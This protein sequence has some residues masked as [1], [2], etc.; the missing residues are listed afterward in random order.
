MKI[1]K[2]VA[3]L[4]TAFFVNIKLLTLKALASSSDLNLSEYSMDETS[5]GAM[6]ASSSNTIM[7]VIALL[8]LPIVILEG[9][10][11]YCKFSKSK[12]K[13]KIII[14]AIAIIAYIIFRICY[15]N[16]IGK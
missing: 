2:K 16:W 1:F 15:F 10:F 14:S 3:K 7:N 4:T 12:K 5:Y 11:I 8:V 13:K 6:P 9:I